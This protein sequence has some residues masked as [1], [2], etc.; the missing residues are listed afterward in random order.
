MSAIRSRTSSLRVRHSTPWSA[1]SSTFQP[2]PSPSVNRP[3]D[4]VTK[5]VGRLAAQRAVLERV[6]DVVSAAAIDLAMLLR[7]MQ[8]SDVIDPAVALYSVDGYT[9]LRW[10]IFVLEQAVRTAL[11]QPRR[12]ARWLLPRIGRTARRAIRRILRTDGAA[13]AR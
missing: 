11:T 2:N 10:A 5:H 9:R 12:A 7:T 1:A 13:S 8:R 3:P 4:R 6:P